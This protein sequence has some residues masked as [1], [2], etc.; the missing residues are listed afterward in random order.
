MAQT[1]TFVLATPKLMP[2]LF[3][4]IRVLCG[5]ENV[6]LDRLTSRSG[7]P[8]L[9]DHEPSTALGMVKKLEA[10][11]DRVTG[12]ATVVESRRN[13]ALLQELE[14]GLRQGC[15]P[16]FLILAAREV[17]SDDSPDGYILEITRWLPY[18][19]S[20]TCVP[21]N[22]EAG[23]ISLGDKAKSASMS[24]EE[25]AGIEKM[26]E[27]AVK[28]T[29][30]KIDERYQGQVV[31]PKPRKDTGMAVKERERVRASVDGPKEGK[32]L[33]PEA[34]TAALGLQLFGGE[35]LPDGIRH[36]SGVFGKVSTIRA[37]FDTTNS[38][39]AISE[40][41]GSDIADAYYETSPRR[42]LALP[43]RVENLRGDQQIPTL[44]QEP[45]SSMTSQGAQRLAVVDATFSSTP[46][47]M[48]PKRLQTVL[49]VSL[50]ATLVSPGFETLLMDVMMEASDRQMALQI[51]RGDGTGV[52]IL[53]IK[54]V[55][56]VLTHEYATTDK[57]SQAGF[58][59]AEDELAVSVP[60]D[61]RAWVLSEDL[62][63]K[64]RRTVREPGSGDYVLRRW[65]GA[66]RILDDA[67]S[68]R[69]NTLEAGYG[70]YGEWSAA[71]LGVW[72]DQQWTVD[73]LTLPGVI[74]ITLDRWF[75]FHVTRPT[76]FVLLSEA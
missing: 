27:D 25:R 11:G 32:H 58:F 68:V 37:A 17:E 3:G 74:K 55:P 26:V 30:A 36:E 6:V 33:G 4:G 64:A 44:T 24:Q 7:L 71:T 29:I 50:E 16:G 47:T 38:Y 70:V 10:T 34:L 41:G 57:G 63:R 19:A 53:G 40:E 8:L 75:A 76:N 43:R 73:R 35:H 5:K 9:A 49:D 12:V 39:G 15:S 23:L 62:Y 31:D 60:S 48:T 20:T 52:N 65:E 69:T 21:L 46:P 28:T 42:I 2:G 59:G 66:Y 54:S 61:R 13:S 14:L 45:N 72:M 56:G 18:E 1:E 67:M 22:P 51:L